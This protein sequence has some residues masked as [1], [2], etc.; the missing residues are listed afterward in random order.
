M[1]KYLGFTHDYGLHY[2]RYPTVL[3]GYN[4]ANWIS[5]VKDSKSQTGYQMLK[6][7]NPIVVMCLQ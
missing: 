6:T 1:L 2:T 5:N 7:Q 3:E 4:D